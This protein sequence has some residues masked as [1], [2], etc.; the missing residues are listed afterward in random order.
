MV[1]NCVIFQG[2]AGPAGAPGQQ[3]ETGLVGLP[4]IPGELGPYGPS[5]PKVSAHCFNFSFHSAFTSENPATKISCFLK[6]STF[7]NFCFRERLDL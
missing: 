7:S 3:G 2:P 4:G 5:G 6:S 1:V